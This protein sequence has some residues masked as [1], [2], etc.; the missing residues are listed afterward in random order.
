[1]SI[2]WLNMTFSLTTNHPK[3]SYAKESFFARRSLSTS[4]SRFTG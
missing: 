1:M 3:M 4:T 2:V